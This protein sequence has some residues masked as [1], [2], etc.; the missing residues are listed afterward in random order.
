MTSIAAP[1]TNSTKFCVKTIALGNDDFHLLPLHE[2]RLTLS[3]A[4]STSVEIERDFVPITV[5]NWIKDRF[6]DDDLTK[7]VEDFIA[8]DDVWTIEFL[9]AIVLQVPQNLVIELEKDVITIVTQPTSVPLP[10][11]PYILQ[12]TTGQMFAVSKLFDDKFHA[13]IGGSLKFDSLSGSFEWM[14]E[15]GR[16]AVPSRLYYQPTVS[17]PLAGYSCVLPSKISST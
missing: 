9:R 12:T 16:I 11:G 10:D 1:I 5:I 17:K 14:H 2:S 4:S 6:T 8:R 7:I 13:F 15:E 3:S